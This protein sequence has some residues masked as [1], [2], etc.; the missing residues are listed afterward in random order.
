MMRNSFIG[1]RDSLILMMRFAGTIVSVGLVYLV[2]RESG[3]IDS[4]PVSPN[5]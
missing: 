3:R 4:C 1:I 2:F 5:L